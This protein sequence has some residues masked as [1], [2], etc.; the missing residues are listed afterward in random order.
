M[1]KLADFVDEL[2]DQ[3]LKK[4]LQR[5]LDDEVTA[6]MQDFEMTRDSEGETDLSLDELIQ[7]LRDL[8]DGRFPGP[9]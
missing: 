6:R 3:R 7:R 1:P 4:N 8:A 2:A 9:K 5:L